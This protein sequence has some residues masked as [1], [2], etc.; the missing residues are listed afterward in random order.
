MTLNEA[1]SKR[2]RQILKEKKITI[3]KLTN[4]TGLSPTTMDNIMNYRTKTSNFKS[5][6]IIIRTL[7]LSMTEFFDNPVFNFENLEI[8]D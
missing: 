3:Y 2:V 8:D 7:G 5:M 4:M 6:A 1:F